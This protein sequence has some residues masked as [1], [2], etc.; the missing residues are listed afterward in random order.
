[1][2]KFS[3]LVDRLIQ[4]LQILPGVGPKSAQRMAFHLLERNTQGALALSQ[5]LQQAIEKVHHCQLCHYFT[6]QD[7]CHI[8]ANEQRAESSQLC[9]VESPADVHAF[10]QTGGYQG[11]YFVLMGK[12]SPIDGI[13]PQDI[14]LDVLETRFKNESFQEVILALSPT[15]EGDAT[16]YHIAEIAQEYHLNVTRIAHGV[17]LGGHLEWI[18]GV[19][20]NHSLQGRQ[21][22]QGLTVDQK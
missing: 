10:E 16:A 11:R 4:Q 12:L 6:E 14:R 2:I 20:L 22:F 8:C 19:T 9:I 1:M 15:V 21:P 5:S 7:Y 3:P 17:P 18:D 13:G